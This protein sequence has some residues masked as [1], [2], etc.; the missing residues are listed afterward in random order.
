MRANL[1]TQQGIP[2]ASG[3]QTASKVVFGSFEVNLATAE[4]FRK[5]RRLRLSGQPAQVLAILLQGAGQ[6]VTREELRLI[7]WPNET[8][9][10]FDHGLNNCINRIREVLGDSALAPKWI[11]TLPKRGYRFIAPIQTIE[12]VPETASKQFNEMTAPEEEDQSIHHVSQGTGTPARL[13]GRLRWIIAVVLV[14]AGLMAGTA[15]VIHRSNAQRDRGLISIQGIAVLPLANLSGDSGQDYLSDGI[16]DELITEL[17]RN[18]SIRVISRTSIMHYKNKPT[19]LPAI[20]RE[21]DVDSV[22]EGSLRRTQDH[23]TIRARLLAARTD[24]PLWSATY[25]GDMGQLP[26]VSSRLASDLSASLRRPLSDASPR[27]RVQAVSPDAY[28]QYLKAQFLANSGQTEAALKHY[29]RAVALQPDYSAAYGGIARSYCAME[30]KQRIPPAEAYP[31]ATAAAQKSLSLDP[32]TPDAHAALSYLYGQRD[33]DQERAEQELKTVIAEDPGSFVGHRWYRY[34]LHST[35]R[36]S[37]ALEQA[38]LSVKADP[39]SAIALREYGNELYDNGKYDEA[40]PTFSEALELDPNNGDIRS[41][42]ADAFEKTGKLESAATE[43]ESSLRLSGSPDIADQFHKQVPSIGYHRA[44]EAARHASLLRDLDGLKKKAARG[45]YVSP[46][47][48]AFTYARLRDRENTLKWL[49]I[50]Y[51]SDSHVM[52]QLR[53]HDFDFVRKDPRFKKI[54]DN[55]PFLH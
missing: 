40:I 6:L 45:E 35:G 22:V 12:Q 55:V 34:M 48:Y 27:P 23:F 54:W 16:T 15:F 28:E 29:Q 41:N 39:E 52:T 33:W 8:F 4:V 25:E 9:V 3:A 20:A 43:L 32:H 1:A 44:A 17:A 42:L 10:D 38:R 50:S 24:T 13:T 21:L 47:A 2:M 18:P 36:Y 37:E 53:E 11:E 14:G 5:G 31:M 30:N 7:L 19:P 46:T 26:Q 51:A 49:E